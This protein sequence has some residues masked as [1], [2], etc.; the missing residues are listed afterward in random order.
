MVSRRSRGRSDTPGRVVGSC[1]REG[2]TFVPGAAA[3]TQRGGLLGRLVG[4]VGV[5]GDRGGIS[6]VQLVG[7]QLL[8][9]AVN[10]VLDGGGPA[11]V[12]L[13]EFSELAGRFVV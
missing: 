4:I 7:L 2:V 12:A 6:G 8:P 11:P 9:R 1:S 13:G 3:R 5:L 10:G